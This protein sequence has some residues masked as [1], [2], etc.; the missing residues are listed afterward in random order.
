M[1]KHLTLSSLQTILPPIKHLIDKKAEN[2]DWN[3]NNP[4]AKGYVKNRPFYVERENGKVLLD[5]TFTIQDDLGFV[6]IDYFE[7]IEGEKYIVTFNG[8]EYSTIGK[9][10]QE[11]DFSYYYLGNGLFGPTNDDT[12]EPF[13]IGLIPGESAIL[14]DIQEFTIT[15]KSYANKYHKIDPKFLPE[16]E[17]TMIVK[18]PDVTTYIVGYPKANKNAREIYEAYTSGKQVY[19]RYTNDFP[20]IPLVACTETEAIFVGN[21]INGIGGSIPKSDMGYDVSQK[22]FR[23]YENGDIEALPADIKTLSGQLEEGLNEK[24]DKSITINGKALNNNITLSASDVKALPNTISIKSGTAA[25]SIIAGGAESESDTYTIGQSAFAEG[26]KTQATALASHAEGFWTKATGGDS[27]SEG[28]K[29]VASGNHSHAEGSGSIASGQ[30]SH[31][32][33]NNTVASGSTSHAEG[34]ETLSSG[35]Y[36][37]AEECRERRKCSC[38]R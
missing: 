11:N 30:I 35:S 19:F 26:H 18:G 23:I 25:N 8:V 2:V 38:R 29:S 4:D 37:H 33:G 1:A 20:L 6:E 17:T 34:K 28:S 13:F 12:G 27:H 3:E 24:A 31:A 16:N 14:S 21:Y 22:A 36:S 32:E 10:F 9:Y 7:I 15:V 5:G